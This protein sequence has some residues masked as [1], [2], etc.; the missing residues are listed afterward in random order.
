MQKIILY[1]KLLQ[2]N[3]TKQN[4]IVLIQAFSSE[5]LIS[6]IVRKNLEN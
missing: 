3:K 4:E 2:K 6:K 1:K 5:S